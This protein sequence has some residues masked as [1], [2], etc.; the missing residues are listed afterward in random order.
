MRRHAI[1]FCLLVGL[2]SWAVDLSDWR[3]DL[4]SNQ[5]F[6]QILASV[7][8]RH[9]GFLKSLVRY[10]A[11]VVRLLRDAGHIQAQLGALASNAATITAA[12]IFGL[13]W[14]DGRSADYDEHAID[15]VK[16]ELKSR[17]SK[18]QQ[19]NPYLRLTSL[20]EDLQRLG[21]PRLLLEVSALLYNEDGQAISGQST[22]PFSTAIESMAGLSPGALETLFSDLFKNHL[23][24]TL[25]SFR[26]SRLAEEVERSFINQTVLAALIRVETGTT[27][28]S[29]IYLE[30]VPKTVAL[31]RGGIGF[32]CSMMSVPFYVLLDSVHVY[33]IRKSKNPKDSPR[34]YLLLAEILLG[35]EIVPYVITVNGETLSAQDGR[36]AILAAVSKY[37]TGKLLV[38]SAAA[39]NVVN[40]DDMESALFQ[41]ENRGQPVTVQ[42][43]DGWDHIDRVTQYGYQRYYESSRLAPALLITL[44]ENEM[45]GLQDVQPTGRHGYYSQPD[46]SQLKPID[47]A[48]LYGDI[49]G[50]D[51]TSINKELLEVL[52]ISES[53]ARLAIELREVGD[54][55]IFFLPSHP[56]KFLVSSN[57]TSLNSNLG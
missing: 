33:W 29:Q 31:L 19:E 1:L 23:K 48:L 52:S 6:V 13:S 17:L 57:L 44:N 27:K 39:T 5:D 21:D 15:R 47:R 46:V 25:T 34:G 55:Q 20:N 2:S 43:P 38:H 22:S 9:S 51:E 37:K 36:A 11:N 12:P 32:D 28:L 42:M 10:K 8:V 26:N 41:K 54:E 16:L 45:K 24:P 53:Q 49:V 7:N 4:A 30:E 40:R 35:D 50:K 14:S 56:R 18:L 3:A